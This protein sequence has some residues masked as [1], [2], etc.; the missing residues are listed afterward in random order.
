MRVALNGGQV[1]VFLGEGT[2][3]LG[4]GK[5]PSY[6]Q[7]AKGVLVINQKCV[8][9]GTVALDQARLAEVMRE[10]QLAFGDVLVNS[11]GMGTL[12]R[13]GVWRHSVPAFPDSHVTVLRFAD[14]FVDPW[15]GAEAVLASQAAIEAL[16]EGS[17]GQTELSRKALAALQLTLPERASQVQLGLK[18]RALHAR[19][20]QASEESGSLAKLRDFL[21]PHLMSGRITVREAEERVEEVL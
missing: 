15:V 7:S 11:T 14:D 9:D 10:P 5:A 13:V 21:L 16:G 4:R 6:T 19:E 1:K 20:H 8:R 18:L 3:L 2:V 12:G 17:T